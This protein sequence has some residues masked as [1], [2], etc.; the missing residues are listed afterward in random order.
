MKFYFDMDG[1]LADFQSMSPDTANF[2][3][4]MD[5]LNDEMRAAKTAFWQNIEKNNNFWRDIPIMPGA[6]DMLKAAQSVGEIFIL[7]KTP[8]AHHFVT[9]Q[10]YIDFVT[11]EKR[12]WVL[13]HLGQFFDAEHIIV[14]DKK[15][16][17]FKHPTPD[18]IL[19]DDRP[20]NITEWNE[21][22]GR[23]ILFT[24]ARNATQEI[25]SYK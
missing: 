23:G 14:C 16:G 5:K 24:N 22:G 18:D 11:T 13:K 1:V 15:K 19:V 4:P 2:N 21:H 7:T 20:E 8:S 12:E 17:A 3:H 6:E 9:G 25:L 10:K